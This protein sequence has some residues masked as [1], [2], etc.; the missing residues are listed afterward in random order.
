MSDVL[1]CGSYTFGY[2]EQW[3]PG[4]A[5]PLPFALDAWDANPSPAN[6]PY[7]TMHDRATRSLHYPINKQTGDDARNEI[8]LVVA[9]CVPGATLMW[10][11]DGMGFPLLASST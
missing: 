3:T 10:Q 11:P 5:P 9:S 8:A 4:V 2:F 7:V 1:S 6:W